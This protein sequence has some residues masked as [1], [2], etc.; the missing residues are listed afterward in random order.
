MRSLLVAVVAAVVFAIP[1]TTASAGSYSDDFTGI[2]VPPISSTLGTFSGVAVGGLAG[3]WYA[4]IEHA[5][6]SSGTT[7]PITGGS[8]TLRTLTG[9]TIA[10]GVTGGTVSV[11]NPGAGCT[12][13]TFAVKATLSDGSF[14]GTLTHY[15]VS[16]FGNCIIYAASLVGSGTIDA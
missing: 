4:Q 2:E 9:R 15:R 6:L 10:A 3:G 1:A 14:S 11:T 7:V 12:K 13:Q 16:I 8:L 5:P